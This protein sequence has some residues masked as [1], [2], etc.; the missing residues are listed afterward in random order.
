MSGLKI[1]NS[2]NARI[3]TQCEHC[4][5]IMKTTADTLYYLVECP[6][7]F[8]DFIVKR[9]QE[10]VQKVIQKAKPNHIRI[11]NNTKINHPDDIFIKA[12]HG[13]SW[14]VYKTGIG[15]CLIGGVSLYGYTGHWQILPG[16][17]LTMVL[18]TVIHYFVLCAGRVYLNSL[19][20]N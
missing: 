14:P 8:R 13:M 17:I 6:A 3:I 5:H 16:C 15:F 19:K 2:P 12:V 7:C 9:F 18:L 20:S 10:P 11:S 1:I 4:S